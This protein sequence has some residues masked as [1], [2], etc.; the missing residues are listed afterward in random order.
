MNAR[1]SCRGTQGLGTFTACLFDVHFA[2]VAKQA[3]GGHWFDAR[4]RAC[5]CV[6]V[7]VCVKAEQHW[8][9]VDL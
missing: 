5:V 1:P 8:E 4:A 2:L 6:C 7:C 3:M 9:F